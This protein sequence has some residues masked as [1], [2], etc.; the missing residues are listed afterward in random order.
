MCTDWG[1]KCLHTL[2]AGTL[3]WAKHCLVGKAAQCLS[4]MALYLA[5]SCMGIPLTCL[6][7]TSVCVCLTPIWE[8][9]TGIVWETYQRSSR[10][11]FVFIKYFNLL[12]LGSYSKMFRDRTAVF[13]MESMKTTKAL[14]S[15]F[16]HLQLL[17]KDLVLHPV[18]YGWGQSHFYKSHFKLCKQSNL[19][20]AIVAP[21]AVF[22][23][24]GPQGWWLQKPLN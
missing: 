18:W 2:T 3:M 16:S 20:L 6:S 10:K 5:L 24:G 1:C 7:V 21:P 4:L 15:V 14:W 12:I 19:L 23:H 8:I 9:P 13:L 17:E 22:S 11:C